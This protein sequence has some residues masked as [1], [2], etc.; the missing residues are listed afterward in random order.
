MTAGVAIASAITRHYGHVAALKWPNDI[1]LSGRKC[2]GILCEASFQGDEREKWFAVIGVGLNVLAESEDFPVSLQET[3]TSLFIETG[4]RVVLDELF[5]DIYREVLE[6]VAILEK[7]GFA[8][9]LEQW[10][11]YDF[12]AG[13]IL[14]W[15]TNS[16]EI[17]L[18]R[19]EG[20]DISGRLQVRDNEGFLHQVV[21]GDVSLV[22]K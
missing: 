16:G 17:V 10:K 1:F 12:L 2:G 21:S 3:A 7:E 15:V 9:L 13:K 8:P 4:R 11:T 6:H 14:Q 18:G 19:S 22:K 5:S 20:P